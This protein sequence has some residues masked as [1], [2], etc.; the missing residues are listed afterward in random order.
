MIEIKYSCKKCGLNRVAVM[1]VPR[2]PRENV[3]EFCN[4]AALQ[5]AA[6]HD[7]RS[8][9]CELNGTLDELMIPIEDDKPIG[10]QPRLQ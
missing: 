10:T 3:V 4:R 7:A 1:V 9:G 2:S 8:P 6:D 5:C